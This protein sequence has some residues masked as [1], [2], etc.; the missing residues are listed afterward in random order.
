MAN[1]EQAKEAKFLEVVEKKAQEK[2]E[3]AKPE[4]KL[5]EKKEEKKVEKKG[6]KAPKTEEKKFVLER[7]YTVNLVEAY[8]KPQT[9]R[10][11]KAVRILRAF[12]ERHMKGSPVKISMSLNNSLRKRGS[13]KPLK[14]VKVKAGKDKDGV[15]FADV[16]A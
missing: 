11:D 9:H 8:K 3:E 14:K 16:A 7:I 15:V 13:V 5:A 1:V 6:E 2:K 10:A 12:L 4:V